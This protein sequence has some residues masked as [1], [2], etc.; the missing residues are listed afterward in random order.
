MSVID[1]NFVQ[2]SFDPNSALS[3]I[4]NRASEY[5][6][7][8][9]DRVLRGDTLLL[10]GGSASI[11]LGNLR[12]GGMK[13]AI[14]TPRNNLLGGG[15]NIEDILREIYS[16]SQLRHRNVLALLGVT[17][18]FDKTLSIVSPW[19]A[20]GNARDYVQDERIDP[21][22]LII[23]I[24]HGLQYLHNHTPDVVLHGDLKGVVLFDRIPFQ[25]NVLISDKGRALLTNFAFSW[26]VD[27]SPGVPS[28]RNI[29]GTVNWMAPELFDGDGPTAEGDVW[30]FGMTALELFTRKNPFHD[31]FGATTIMGRIV[32]G[33][34]DRP[35][36]NDT[37]SRMTD[38]WWNILTQCWN[39]DPS[40]RPTISDVVE[41]VAALKC[42]QD[43]Y[44][45]NSPSRADPRL[46]LE[47]LTKRASQH[48][49][50]I[51]LNGKVD[52]DRSYLIRGGCANVVRGTLLPEC[53]RVAI[54]TA[55]GV[56]PREEI[57]HTL[58]E[59]HVWSKLRHDNV[60]QLLGITTEFDLTVSIISPWMDNGNAHDYVQD[61]RI[62]PCPLIEGVAQGL[63][64]LHSSKIIHG[65]MK[66]AST[67]CFWG[68][69]PLNDGIS[70]QYNVLISDDG[71]ALLTDFGF[72]R[73]EN[74][75]FSISSYTHD[76]VRG[77]IR[78]IAP[79]VL[80]GKDSKELR[81]GADVWSFGMTVLE[82]FTRADPFCG[83]SQVCAIMAKIVRGP[84]DRPSDE[85]TC[86][87]LTDEWWNLC[88]ACWNSDP[89]SRPTMLRIVHQ[90]TEITRSRKNSTDTITEPFETAEVTDKSFAR[91]SVLSSS[92]AV[93]REVTAKASTTNKP[94]ESLHM[95]VKSTT[96][97][98]PQRNTMGA[99]GNPTS[100][101]NPQPNTMDAPAKVQE[102]VD[103]VTVFTCRNKPLQSPVELVLT[104]APEGHS[105]LA[106]PVVW[107]VLNR[108][109]GGQKYAIGIPIS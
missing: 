82:L 61:S 25:F 10:Q 92:G 45:E 49:P 67:L 40:L 101:E 2:E 23:G 31:R 94:V 106:G 81:A 95:E 28:S 69:V 39:N 87:R 74:S 105:N 38:T 96:R 8:L 7:N 86:R 18:K 19:M 85:D 84:P 100:Q 63:S 48:Y 98:N 57:V 79:E 50:D 99:S 90:I 83:L 24:A 73:L 76:K 29:G 1:S 9:Y 104:L 75:S 64:Y 3:E 72:S 44:S 107:Q 58:K 97:A 37:S 93:Q 108:I 12:P 32:N 42:G 30:A 88:F 59:V 55:R 103:T 65:D 47:E 66:G 4:A 21:C 56:L 46:V 5:N 89:F 102:V 33:P 109:P 78:W 62:D 71:R 22:P 20:R 43:S 54:K 11:Y 53:L 34:P 52:R 17:T 77:S 26:H 35:S 13:V 16:W 80:D 15:N 41:M 27:I 6:I 68:L 36:D 14:K 51:N 70:L 60:L 91:Y